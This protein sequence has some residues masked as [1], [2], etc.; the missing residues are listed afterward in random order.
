ML[1]HHIACDPM[2][3]AT[4]TPILNQL[5]IEISHSTWY[6]MKGDPAFIETHRGT[7]PGGPWA[8]VLFHLLFTRVA[9]RVDEQPEVCSIPTVEW[10]GRREPIPAPARDQGMQLLPV[11]DSTY[12]DD[13]ASVHV[14]ILLSALLPRYVRQRGPCLR[15]SVR[16][17]WSRTLGR[18]NRC[19]A[20][21]SGVCVQGGASPAVQRTEG[22]APSLA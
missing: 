21:S 20:R 19:P 3:S 4:G 12:A 18:Q 6:V 9:S 2:I 8:D 10:D 16:V 7:R 1:A 15:P 17:V 22:S 14:V 5:T 13:L 11:R